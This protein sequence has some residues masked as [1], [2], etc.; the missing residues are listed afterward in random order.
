MDISKS[1]GKYRL[2]TE[3]FC[4]PKDL[5]VRLPSFIQLMVIAM[6]TKVFAVKPPDSKGKTGMMGTS[7]VSSSSTN[8][9]G[10]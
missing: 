6:I 5:F 8:S 9:S 10:K 1:I 4:G 2:V 7:V 3:P